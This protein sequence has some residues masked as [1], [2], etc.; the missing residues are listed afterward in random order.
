MAMSKA[1]KLGKVRTADELAVRSAYLQATRPK[2]NFA[3]NVP[4]P[5]LKSFKQGGSRMR[6]L[7]S[8]QA[9]QER[10]SQPSRMVIPRACRRMC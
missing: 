3:V 4:L 10:G 9:R 1:R 8:A 5:W 7:R 2:W 6:T